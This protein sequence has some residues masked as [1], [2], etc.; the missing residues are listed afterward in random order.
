MTAKKETSDVK[1]MLYRKMTVP[2]SFEILQLG[3]RD[4][5]VHLRERLESA[6]GEEGM[7][8]AD[9]DGNGCDRWCDRSFEPT[10]RSRA[11]ADIVCGWEGNG[12]VALEDHCQEAPS[13]Q[14]HHH[15][16]RDLH[17][18]EG[19]LAGFVQSFQVLDA[20]SKG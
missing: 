1:S 6:H 3:G 15:H 14:D 9:Q 19:L 4:F 10:E 2:G 8:Q 20:R 7:P 11:E 17:D 5:A 12:L 18:S 13:D 16:G